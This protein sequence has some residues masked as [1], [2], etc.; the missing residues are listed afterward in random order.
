ML[1]WIQLNYIDQETNKGLEIMA[2][3]SKESY[4][5]EAEYF[6][7]YKYIKYINIYFFRHSRLNCPPVLKKVSV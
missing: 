2:R 5:K 3:M 7:D 1:Y 4:T 6:C